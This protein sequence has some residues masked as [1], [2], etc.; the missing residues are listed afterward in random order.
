[1][2]DA[3]GRFLCKR[4]TAYGPNGP[5]AC[6]VDKK[7]AATAEYSPSASPLHGSHRRNKRDICVISPDW[8]A[9]LFALNHTL[10]EEKASKPVANDF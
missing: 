7:Q 2:T 5:P 10:T 6:R 9:L 3:A 4:S 1:M 8:Q